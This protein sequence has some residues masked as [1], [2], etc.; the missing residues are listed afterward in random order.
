[1]TIKLNGPCK[2]IVFGPI[3]NG[4]AHEL[5]GAYVGTVEQRR[6]VLFAA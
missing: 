2:Q 4:V 5:N 1:M 3:I 6:V